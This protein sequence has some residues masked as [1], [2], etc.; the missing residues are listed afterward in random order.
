LPHPNNQT[1]IASRIVRCLATAA[2]KVEVMDVRIGLGYTAVL[3]ADGRAGL[4]YT[5][6]GGA[7]AGCSPFAGL[8]PLATRPA[9]DLV[10]LLESEDR[11]E[12]AVGLACAN[13]L[14]NRRSSRLQDGD[15]LGQLDLGAEDDV[16]MVGHFGPL[17]RP[18]EAR[19]RSLVI[20]ERTERGGGDVRPAIEAAERISRSHVA[21]ITATSIINHTIDAL[22]HAAQSCREV[23][24]LGASTPLLPEA[25]SAANVTLLSGVLVESPEQIL[26]VVSEGGG[27]RFFGPHVRKVNLHLR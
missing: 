9:A 12:A 3:L 16:A 4:A 19:A 20:V 22:L 6:R 26:R 25:F 1:T 14:A 27:M 5:F 8:R 7:P 2:R 23:V 21:L 11:L 17:V 10:R 15:V 13:A 18:L 24:V